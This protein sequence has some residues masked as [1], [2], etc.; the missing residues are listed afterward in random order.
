M[1]EMTLLNCKI[2]IEEQLMNHMTTPVM[3]GIGKVLQ[4][5]A[6]GLTALMGVAAVVEKATA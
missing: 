4:K 6:G 3:G 2:S 1:L 5:V